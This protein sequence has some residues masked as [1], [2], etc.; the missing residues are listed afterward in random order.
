MKCP[1]CQ[2]EN[3]EGI[4]FCGECGAKLEK[5]CPKCNSL[6]PPQFKFCGECG[7]EL[8]KPIEALPIDYSEPQSYTP[9]F[10]ADKILTTRS[11]IEGERKLVT[12]LFAD[13]ANYTAMAEKL[14]PEEV[15]QIM[16][17]CFNILMDEI[18]R[19]EGTVNQFTGD[20]VM[21]LFGAPVAHED[22]AQRACHAALSIQKAM[23]RYSDKLKRERK[24][25][26]K[27]RIGLNSG[28]VVVGAIGDDLR[29]DYTAVGDTTNLA[30][31]MESIARPGA[32]LLTDH[33]H[34]LTRDFFEFQ[35]LGKV[36]VKGKKAVQEAYELIR[37]TEVETRIEAAAA[38]GLTK[39]VGRT[40]EAEALKEAFE[41]AQ[42]GSGQV[43]GVV[44]EAGVGKS[45]LLLELR[46]MLPMGEYTYLEGRCI[47]YGGSMAYLPILGILRSY[48]DIKEG[49]QEAVIK[50]KMEEKILQL[51][52]NL[53]STFPPLQ[54]ILSLKVEDEAYLKVEPQEK[55][56]RT[57]EAIRNLLVRESQNRPL[58]LAV[59]DLHWIDR[60]S[61]EFLT[62]LIRW[63]ANT[64]I[65][66][67][68]LYRPEYTHT[69]GSKSYYSKIGVDQLSTKS[70]VE[71]VQSILEGAEVVPKLSELILS[72]AGGNPLFVEEFTHSL[73]E[74]GSIQRKDYQYVLSTKA[75]DIQVPDTI[76]GI[77]AARMDRLED[78]LKH[79]MQV[80]SVIGRD[81]AF[82][83]LQTITGMREEIKSY[84]LNLQGLEFIY[85]KKLFP[86]LEYIFKHALTQEVAYNSLLVQRRKEIHEK[87]G[88]AIEELYPER[89]EEFYEML[90]YH[91]TA[92]G[93]KERALGYLIRASERAR[94]AASHREEAALLTRALRI[95]EEIKK[96]DLLPDLRARCGRAYAA[97][98]LW[99]KAKPELEE[100]LRRLPSH[101][102][103]QQAEVM[104]ELA[105]VCFWLMDTPSLRDY[106][107]KTL[108]IAKKVNRHDLESAAISGL[109]AADSLEGQL[110]SSMEQYEIAITQSKRHGT[111]VPS[112]A[113]EFYSLELYWVGKLDEAIEWSRE[114]VQSC[115]ERGDTF[116]LMR[117]LS[118]L[119]IS[120]ASRG[121]YIEALQIFEE[122]QQF[123]REYDLGTALARC[124][125]MLGGVH[126][127]LYD[128]KTA[129]VITEE[130]KGI[131]ASLNFP[132]PIISA[133]I[134][135]LFNFTRR[136]K[137]GRAD[138]FVD[139]VAEAVER[140]SGWH[141]WLW[142]MRLAQAQAEIGLAHG[143]GEK[144]IQ[145][146]EKSL[147]QSQATG[148]IKYQAAA[149]E[150][151]GKAL[152]LMGNERN[153]GIGDL[154]KAIQLVRPVQDPLMFL[155]AA[156]ALLCIE[157]DKKLIQEVGK[158]VTQIKKSLLNTPV[159]LLFEESEPVRVLSQ[160]TYNLPNKTAK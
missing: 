36:E 2:F 41:K 49:D 147:H 128:F 37:A 6:N 84:L 40:K 100:A 38:K 7:H 109:A 69:W 135:L 110:S 13:V 77:I 92:A 154:Q 1:K 14:D 126:L 149:L 103:E 141:G 79:T 66:L 120:L 5:V 124:M 136:G 102:I 26:F 35:P 73:L 114:A 157:R 123:G 158:V 97:I 148:R 119:G 145:F 20:G 50:K 151:R 22:H 130:A 8:S 53:K 28:P 56:M 107:N 3:P 113:L 90:A 16:D 94:R 55:R 19:C 25:D 62:Y 105:I 60:T 32:I 51:D 75:L 71:L 67:I 101:A 78:N 96:V 76:Q 64:K 108:S 121:R 61:E 134:D 146:A 142:K 15:H 59:E 63:L 140:T 10:L 80:A 117:A 116:P 52:E 144:A 39:F 70:S 139:K 44:G 83:I 30:A 99:G 112:H 17:G 27:M 88:R 127:E 155:R 82:R 150:T 132:P 122:A 111:A 23:T 106:S 98:G 33:T 85:E 57:F 65:L 153:K 31:R 89:L 86:E 21:A 137:V 18:H 29:M 68:F 81:F 159:Y 129:Q 118:N 72:R 152:V 160:L 24:I 12:V 11:S 4:K 95:A 115:R 48:L 91:A 54:E 9:K 58:V 87:I 104:A 47:H 43:V 143:D 46:N 34:K 125:V 133:N 131:A 74:N 42:S 156:Y 138:A 45:R 93:Q